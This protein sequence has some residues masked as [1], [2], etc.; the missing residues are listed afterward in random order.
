MSLLSR[1]GDLQIPIFPD[2]EQ[3]EY[4]FSTTVSKALKT[5]IVSQRPQFA[6]NNNAKKIKSKTKLTKMQQHN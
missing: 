2:S 5:S 3:K 4:E 1:F 6:T